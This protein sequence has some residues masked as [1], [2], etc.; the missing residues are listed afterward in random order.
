MIKFINETPDFHEMVTA[1]RKIEFEV[2]DECSLDELLDA[3]KSF[4]LASGYS[5]DGRVDI[6]E[7]D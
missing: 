5:I 3:F 6:V 7:D 1:I 2:A 4:L